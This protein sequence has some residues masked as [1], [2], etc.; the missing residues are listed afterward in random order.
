MSGQLPS[1][2]LTSLTFGIQTGSYPNIVTYEDDIPLEGLTAGSNSYMLPPYSNT[3]TALSN[4]ALGTSF[5]HYVNAN[6]GNGLSV[7]T[8]NAAQP[9]VIVPPPKL[10]LDANRVTVKYTGGALTSWPTFLY[11]DPRGTGSNELFVVVDDTSK[12]M[13]QNYAMSMAPGFYFTDSYGIVVPFKNIVTTLMTDMSRMFDD[14]SVFNKEI[15]SWDTS[16]VTNMFRMFANAHAFNQPIGSWNT[17]NVRNMSCMLFYTYSFNQPI[18]SWNTGNVTDMSFM[19]YSNQVFNQPIGLWNTSN[20]TN[21]Q[22]M[23]YGA[24]SFNQD[25]SA[26]V[27]KPF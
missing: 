12:S 19:F 22:N 18:G 23:F 8:T 25:I 20:V 10:V 14:A 11:E 26:W 24:W 6:H 16:N 9:F 21:M 15:G 4:S 5:S 13:I 1:S 17:S 7:V 3:F 27:V 2:S